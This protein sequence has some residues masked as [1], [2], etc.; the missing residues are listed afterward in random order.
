MP[1]VQLKVGWTIHKSIFGYCTDIWWWY[2]IKGFFYAKTLQIIEE[3][4][5]WDKYF[6]VINSITIRVIKSLHAALWYTS[7][8]LP[9][10]MLLNGTFASNLIIV[11]YCRFLDKK[12]HIEPPP[13]PPFP[14]V[15][16]LL[17]SQGG[18]SWVLSFVLFGGFIFHWECETGHSSIT[19]LP[20]CPPG[21]SSSHNV[22]P[23]WP[24][25][26]D[27]NVCDTEENDVQLCVR[28]QQST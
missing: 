7:N 1:C 5:K 11:Q 2:L 25:T 23:G 17:N 12:V 21:L 13:A 27:A 20:S 14:H 22:G 15:S 28:G 4:D 19:D 6:H 24:L 26:S 8:D 10:I 16:P 9:L 3:K 18:I